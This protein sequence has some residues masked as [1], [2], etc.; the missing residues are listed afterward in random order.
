MTS[1]TRPTPV[2]STRHTLIILGV[3]GAIT[4]ASARRTGGSPVGA[5]GGNHLLQYGILLA[6]EWLLFY[7]V[8][9]GLRAHGTPLS[10]IFGEAPRAWRGRSLTLVGGVAAL[11]F[12]RLAALV[13]R[14]VL[15]HFGAPVDAD[16]AAVQA[17]MGPHGLVESTLWVALSISAGVCE[18]FVYR[19][20]L[21]KQF[22]AWFGGPLP[23]LLLSALVFGLGHAYQGPWQV[24]LITLGY[25]LPFGAVALLARG[26][27]PSIVAHALEDII[28]GLFGG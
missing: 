14:Q 24:I 23:G 16:A 8:W 28:A 22:S 4:L 7:G 10:A 21:L 2:A 17:A 19:G 18:E 5:T 25:G 15:V 27:R 3:V 12:V 11:A 20:Y 26:L 6:G 9:R 1:T 13:T